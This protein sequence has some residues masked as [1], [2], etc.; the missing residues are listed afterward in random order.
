MTNP[1]EIFTANKKEMAIGGN[2]TASMIKT[3]MITTGPTNWLRF[4][5]LRG[6]G[7]VWALAM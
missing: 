5:G 2:G 1:A 3:S 7:L 6:N 4:V